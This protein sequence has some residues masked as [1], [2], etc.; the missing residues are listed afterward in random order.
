[1]TKNNSTTIQQCMQSHP[2]S[3]TRIGWIFEKNNTG[4]NAIVWMLCACPIES[5]NIFM[6]NSPGEKVFRI[7]YDIIFD[8][9]IQLL[10]PMKN[11]ALE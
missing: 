5:K 11:L 6:I 1:M 7:S 8:R 2:K 4:N 3:E 9:F 10:C